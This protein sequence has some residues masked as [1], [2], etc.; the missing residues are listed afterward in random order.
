MKTSLIIK[1]QWQESTRGEIQAWI[2]KVEKSKKKKKKPFKYDENE[3]AKDTE[4]K[5][6][7]LLNKELSNP[8]RWIKE[9]SSSNRL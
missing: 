8:P 1:L 2:Q 7:T 6:C 3:K 9:S 4:K 5:S